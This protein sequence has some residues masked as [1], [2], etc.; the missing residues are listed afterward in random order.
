MTAVER[1]RQGI[2]LV[3]SPDV[4]RE[5]AT[6]SLAR[7]VQLAALRTFDRRAVAAWQAE[8]DRDAELI[9]RA[10]SPP[11]TTGDA[12][13][14][15]HIVLHFLRNLIPL[16]AGAALLDLCIGLQFDG[17]AEI[18]LP[19]LNPGSIVASWISEGSAIPSRA[20]QTSGGPTLTPFKLAVLVSLSGEMVRFTAAEELIKIVLNESVGPSIDAALFGAAAGVPGLSPPG[21]LN[22]IVPLAPATGTIYEAM[23]S[24]LGSL[25]G[26]VS[27]SAG[28]GQIVYVL[29]PASAVR[30]N[31]LMQGPNPYKLFA[32]TA[33]PAGTAI[34]LASNALVSVTEPLPRV[35]ASTEATVHEFDPA[36]PLV[37][38]GGGIFASPVRS[39]FQTDSVS[40][41]LLL[42]ISWALRNSAAVSYMTG[43]AW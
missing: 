21:L 8:G 37:D 35:E 28:N 1:R 6:R 2:P 41:R 11:F 20:G 38:I 42:P 12:S 22:G 18:R 10:P 25:G 4:L 16:S 39:Q 27:G 36:S 5:R 30:A 32:S 13:A 9:L 33:L 19:Q 40:L 26:A 17:A 29:N 3:P 24:D 23:M 14:F 34:A 31:I 15:T 43:C 7:A